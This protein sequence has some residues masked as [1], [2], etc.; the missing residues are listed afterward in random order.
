MLPREIMCVCGTDM[1]RMTSSDSLDLSYLLLSKQLEDKKWFY[2]HMYMFTWVQM[3][4]KGRGVEYDEYD[5]A[6]VTGDRG[7]PDTGAGNL[8]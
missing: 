8:T 6:V 7:P 2:T 1:P 3:L 4:A 5:A